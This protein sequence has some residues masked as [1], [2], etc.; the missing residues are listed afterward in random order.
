MLS[1]V[2]YFDWIDTAFS[3]LRIFQP[4]SSWWRPANQVLDFLDYLYNE[5]VG[6]EVELTGTTYAMLYKLYQVVVW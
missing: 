4:G 3:L 2:Y 1:L 5:W 6:R